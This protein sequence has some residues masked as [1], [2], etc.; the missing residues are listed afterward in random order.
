MAR[1]G[2]TAE[3]P[4]PHPEKSL[5]AQ[6]LARPE[7]GGPLPPHP[8]V[9]FSSPVPALG[10]PGEDRA[11]IVGR[12]PACLGSFPAWNQGRAQGADE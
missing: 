1:R 7:W 5:E 11:K 12:P 3:S 8:H 2:G 6:G 4:G 10:D 9:A